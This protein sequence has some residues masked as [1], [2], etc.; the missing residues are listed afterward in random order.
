M[1]APPGP[2]GAP[3]TA[4]FLQEATEPEVVLFD[5]CIIQKENRSKLAIRKKDTH[6][7]DQKPSLK[8]VVVDEPVSQGPTGLFL[9]AWILKFDPQPRGGG[10]AFQCSANTG[11]VFYY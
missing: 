6:F 3:H 2:A 4:P 7:L 8:T 10:G 5:E 1:H 11:N 9:S